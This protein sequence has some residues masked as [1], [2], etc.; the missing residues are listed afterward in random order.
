MSRIIAL[1]ALALSACAAPTHYAG[2]DLRPGSADPTLQTLADRARM[3]SKQAQL[4]L[5]IRYEDGIGLPID[6]KRARQLYGLAAATTGGTIYVYQAPVRKGGRGSV[7]PVNT[8]PVVS[9]L[10][11]AKERLKAMKDYRPNPAA[12]H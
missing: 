12:V 1:I 8:G 6:R 4:E 5:G 9:G 11:A 10:A 2:V 3:G 7:I